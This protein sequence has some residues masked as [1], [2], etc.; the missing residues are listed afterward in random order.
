MME[1]KGRTLQSIQK[2]VQKNFGSEGFQ[3]WLNTISAESYIIYNGDID[4]DE[5]F[6]LKTG[7]V[8]PMA[9]IAQLF[10]KWDLKAASWEM[11]R[12]NADFSVKGPYKLFARLGSVKK[13]FLK[14]GDFL[15]NNYRPCEMQ[16]PVLEDGR[17]FFRVTQFPEMDKT[18]EFR[19]AGWLDRILEINGAEER[20]VEIAKAISN[21]DP[22]TEFRATWRDK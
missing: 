18:V 2:Y 5:W 13:F 7:M 17:A 20:K 16:T 12:Y 8:Q 14:A 15:S 6:S 10:F 22:Y 11:G 9:N 4:A 21:R 19:I 3:K 1:V